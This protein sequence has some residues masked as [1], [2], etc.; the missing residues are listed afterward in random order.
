MTHHRALLLIAISTH[1]ALIASSPQL[2]E[3][4]PSQKR[5]SLLLLTFD[6]LRADYVGVYGKQGIETATLDG[7]AADG[8]WFENA[9][10]Q[11]PSTP[12]SHASILT[13]TYP[14][15]H[16]VRDF[17][18]GPLSDSVVSLTT[19]LRQRG[20]RTAAFV[21]SAAL[22]SVWG[23]DRSF[24]VYDDRFGQPNPRGAAGGSPE[25]RAQETVSKALQ[26]LAA[27]EGPF[28][29]WVHLFDPHHAYD[30]PEPFRSRYAH[31]LYAG[32][33]AYAD[34]HAGRLIEALKQ[35]GEY[36]DSLII[37]VSDH[38]ESLGEHGELNHGL[39]LY[40]ATTRVPLI[41]KLPASYG[42]RGRKI[43]GLTETVDI[44]PSALQ[45]L[46]IAPQRDWP[47]EGKGRLAAMLGKED[48]KNQAYSE[49]I[50]PLTTF[51]WSP[52]YALRSGRH[53]LIEAPRPELYDL[54]EDAGELRNLFDTNTALGEQLRSRLRVRLRRS[55]AASPEADRTQPADPELAERLASLGYA[56]VSRAVASEDE[57]DQVDRADPKDKVEVY[58]LILQAT[59][60]ARGGRPDRANAILEPLSRS[61]PELFIVHYTIGL[62]YLKLNR[63]EKALESLETARGLNPDYASID[64][65][66][67][68]ALAAL[69]RPEQAEETLRGLLRRKPAFPAAQHQLGQL[70]RR[71]GQLDEAVSL[72]R[73]MLR[74]RPGD[75]AV[76]RM[77][78]VCLVDVRAYPEGLQLLEQA[79]RGGLDDALTR[80]YRGIALANLGRR[81]E[82]D[83][84]Y[85]AA[86]EL[87]AGYSQARL[88]LA[89][90]LL[91]TGDRAKAL[92]EFNRVCS[93]NRRLCEQYRNRFDPR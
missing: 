34:S 33:V 75:P 40:D 38:G 26:W 8:A 50:Y 58:R 85:R 65:N 22:D 51:G 20:Y 42:V 45:I 73:G 18:S 1:L 78:G 59:D 70:L 25:R 43:E 6:T 41:Y 67:A 84:S 62:N 72:Y 79:Q 57:P 47:I 66:R 74:Q 63:P 46:R 17:T 92:E 53:K 48:S 2:P 91:E 4:N 23:L 36:R 5:P 16:G 13:G 29:L 56:A 80:N 55:A 54:E 11:V 19:I 12:P 93:R 7:L 60:A 39:F 9:Y 32:E 14:R 90:L 89:F 3:R 30:P 64:L 28:F 83:R 24:E 35:R 76:L 52:L 27:V 37:A 88:N 44:L 21:S 86:L 31:D 69:G 61:E 15:T 71:R 87:N 81:Q 68:Q 82:A 49:S 77:L 10:C